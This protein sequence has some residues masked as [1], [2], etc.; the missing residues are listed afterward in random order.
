MAEKNGV[1]EVTLPDGRQYE[2]TA[3]VGTSETQLLQLARESE[4]SSRT[5]GFGLGVL[6]VPLSALN[7]FVI[8]GG[9]AIS[10]MSKFISDP[11]IEAGLNLISPG[12]GTQSR[13]AAE[14][15]RLRLSQELS[16]QTVARPTPVAREA[17]GITASLLSGGLKLPSVAATSFPRLT[18]ATE[19]AIQGAVGS[20]SVETPGMTTGEA[21]AL[22]AGVN[23]A[24]P[25]AM[26]ALLETRPAQYVGQKLGQLATPLVSKFD[27]GADVLRRAIGIGPEPTPSEAFLPSVQQ[28]RQ[29]AMSRLAVPAEIQQA[30]P[31]VVEAFGP[32]AAQRLRNFARVGV[33]QPTT[34][35]IT[36]EPGIWSYERNTM[37]RPN[38]GEPIRDAIIKVNDE[39]NTAV[40]NFIGRVGI[41]D[42]VEKVGIQ[43]SEAL[44]KKQEEMQKVV[45]QLYKSAR[46]Q[47]G[48]KSAGSVANFL[49]RLEDPNL[50][51]DAAFDTFRQS[52]NNRLSRFGMLGDSG[53]PRKDA[54]MTV[55][56]AE[57]MRRFI[58]GLGSGSDPNVR[59]IRGDLIE[60]LDDDV[61]AGF[62]SDA[63][64][65]AR[66]AAKA[67]FGEFKD[68]LAGKIGEGVIKSDAVTKKLMSQ[69]TG[70]ADIRKLKSTLLSGD[71]DQVA[72]GQQAWSS[73]AAQSVTDLFQKARTGD[74]LLSGTLLRKAFNDK[75]ANPKFREL[76]TRDEFVQL[77]RIVRAAGDANID[78]DFSSIN[79]SGTA[80]ELEAIISERT[81]EPR[82]GI[83]NMI[84]Q[85]AMA[86]TPA[87]GIG[88]VALMAGQKVTEKAGE[89]AAKKAA[90]MMAAEQASLITRPSDV[91][92]QVI[93]GRFTP[94]PIAPTAGL[95]AP[96]IISSIAAAENPPAEQQGDYA[97]FF[98]TDPETGQ[99]IWYNFNKSLGFTPEQMRRIAEGR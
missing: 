61:V 34:G 18:A 16:R 26:R 50:V 12:Y 99:K 76:L 67:R 84:A 56:Q 87:G 4:L 91:A 28:T 17:G 29:E 81:A 60:A 93:R 59:R 94:E 9:E 33:T 74:N 15:Q 92:E 21:A 57:E 66:S 80:A 64:Q 68:T 70:I 86:L 31:D 38:V 22:G 96:G 23:V 47:Y 42:D 37:K 27:E 52:I 45:G 20:Q 19:R 10:G 13:Q 24:L 41:A 43:A 75:F 63:F 88:N 53:L 32:E 55:N 95:K 25:P 90:E 40:D 89:T 11:V 30:I 78:V 7:E 79:R 85:L 44:R 2:V 46:E 82:A 8:G 35:M 5:Q 39:I 36:R 51:D 58:G 14:E 3:P 62:G 65:Q 98:A 77:N 49:N 54:V 48:E 73:I 83:R 69:S 71:R 97:G 72:R 1:Y 6:D